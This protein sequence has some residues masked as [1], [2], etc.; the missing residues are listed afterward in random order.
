MSTIHN[1]DALFETSTCRIVFVDNY[2]TASNLKTAIQTSHPQYIDNMG[3]KFRA[4]RKVGPFK[5]KN[6]ASLFNI[7]KKTKAMKPEFEWDKA[8]AT[9]FLM[10]ELEAMDLALCSERRP[11][12]LSYLQRRRASMLCDM[13]DG[14]YE[15][16]LNDYDTETPKDPDKRIASKTAYRTIAHYAHT[17]DSLLFD[18]CSIIWITALTAEE[19]LTLLGAEEYNDKYYRFYTLQDG[20]IAELDKAELIKRFE[21]GKPIVHKPIAPPSQKPAKTAAKEP[22][23]EASK[24]VPTIDEFRQVDW[25]AYRKYK[26]KTF[27]VND[28]TQLKVLVTL[29]DNRVKSK[30]VF[31]SIESGSVRFTDRYRSLRTGTTYAVVCPPVDVTYLIL[32]W[33]VEEAGA[34]DWVEDFQELGY[35]VEQIRHY[36][37]SEEYKKLLSK[38]DPNAVF[39]AGDH[40]IFTGVGLDVI[41]YEGK[42][43]T[44][45]TARNTFDIQ[46][47]D[48]LEKII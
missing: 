23:K 16:I 33:A 22:A 7:L 43:F 21:T 41:A 12:A 14:H 25:D 37:N 42:E 6:K 27:T 8:R 5:V 10:D 40:G 3:E 18:D 31:A 2:T 45:E 24:A 1:I 17:S 26:M 35:D 44:D 32:N 11:T 39:S 13:L 15:F 38:A 29:T 34:H 9:K 36:E 19:M 47:G 20:N 46:Q 28:K 4:F 48:I 30:A